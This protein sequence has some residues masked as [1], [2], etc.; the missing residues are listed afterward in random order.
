[1]DKDPIFEERRRCPRYK[2][3]IPAKILLEYRNIPC[4]IINISEIGLGILTP[5]KLEISSEFNI[6]I[7]CSNYLNETS[8]ILLKTIVVWTTTEK[9]GDMFRAGLSVMDSLEKD[10]LLLRKVIKEIQKGT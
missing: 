3:N 5:E 10:A 9:S 7:D 6:E 4:T 2:I 1:M 8:A